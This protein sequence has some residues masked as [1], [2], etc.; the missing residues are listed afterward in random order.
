MIQPR[1]EIGASGAAD[2]TNRNVGRYSD[3]AESIH[4]FTLAQLI[5]YLFPMIWYRV[6]MVI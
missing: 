3:S 2:T 1:G 4:L 6:V 5:V